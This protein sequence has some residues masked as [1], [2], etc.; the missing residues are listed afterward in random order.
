MSKGQMT[1]TQVKAVEE[2]A[3]LSAEGAIH[4]GEVI[5]RLVANDIERYHA[6]YSCDETTYYAASGGS[7]IVQIA[8]EHGEI[9]Q[10]FSAAGVESAV[11]QSQRGEIRYPEFTRQ[12]VA[13]GC[14]GYFVLIAG[15]CVQYFGRRGEIHTE[16]FPGAKPG[17]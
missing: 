3:R 6:D 10:P 16:W 14:V 7:C 2:C 17:T 5:Q 9:A 13:A 15:K 4:F 11:R 8:V 1:Q 12:A